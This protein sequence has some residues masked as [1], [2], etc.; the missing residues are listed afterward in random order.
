MKLLACCFTLGL[1]ATLPAVADLDLTPHFVKIGG[2]LLH[3]AYFADGDKNYSM[4]I[5]GETEISGENGRAVFRFTNVSQ[6]SMILHA[7]PFAKP[8]PFSVEALP[9]YAKAA[10][11]ML[12]PSA[13][14]VELAWQGEN[15]FP[16]NQWKSYRYTFRYRIGGLGFQESVTYLVLDNGQ[17]IVVQ[18]GC[19]RKDFAVISARAD[20]TMRRWTLVQPGDEKG[21]N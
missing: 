14:G 13:E 4:T 16:I 19:P 21:E 8:A 3:R 18:T 5:D 11:A 12:P 17:Q 1:L 10:Q 6:A 15:V 7:S 20:D 9:D 2:G